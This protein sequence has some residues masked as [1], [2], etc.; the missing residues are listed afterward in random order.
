[1][2]A[3]MSSFSLWLKQ[4]IFRLIF[5]ILTFL[6]ASIYS[7]KT[8]VLLIYIYSIEGFKF[9]PLIYSLAF[10]GIVFAPPIL[11]IFRMLPKNQ[12][13]YFGYTFSEI[14]LKPFICFL[15]CCMYF[16]I[17]TFFFGWIYLS[18]YY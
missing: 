6:L 10:I 3:T 12:D 4:N 8:V 1:M 9:I 5:F 18:F 11:S 7:I 14:I 13:A 16:A 17:S 2:K 15:L